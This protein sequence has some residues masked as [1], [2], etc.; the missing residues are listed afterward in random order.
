MD[1]ARFGV[2]IWLVLPFLVYGISR[3]W[4]IRKFPSTISG[5]ILDVSYRYGSIIPSWTVAKYTFDILGSDYSG[6]AT[7]NGTDHKPGE[8]VL[9]RYHPKRPQESI[10]DRP[11][12]TREWMVIGLFVLALDLGYAVFAVFVGLF[13]L[14][15]GIFYAL[16]RL[17]NL[18]LTQ[19]RT[20]LYALLCV[21][22]GLPF[23]AMGVYGLIVDGFLA[24]NILWMLWTHQ[25][26]YGTP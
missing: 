3:A 8:E 25:T 4:L 6:Q 13:C 24:Q 23:V 12:S 5:R 18:Q 19:R 7:L 9:I 1:I 10:I 20:I 11:P 26:I 22:T 14:L 21:L 16:R 15:V 2:L 17:P